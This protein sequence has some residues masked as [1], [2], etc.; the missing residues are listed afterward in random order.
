[1]LN[2]PT[3]TPDPTP[4]PNPTPD[5]NPNPAP[6]PNPDPTPVDW[7]KENWKDFLDEDLKTDPSL[8][9][10]KD[11]KTLAKSYVHAQR[12]VGADKIVVPNKYATD[13]E[14]EGIFNKLGRPESPDKYELKLPE[15]HA[16]SDEFLTGIKTTAHKAG[17]NSKQVNEFVNFYQSQLETSQK[18]I[19]ELTKA[20]TE[21]EIKALKQ[22]WGAAYDSKIKA[23]QVALK[24]FGG[25]EIFKYLEEVGLH[26]DTKLA[27][28][29]A[30]IGESLGEDKGLK[31]E[32]NGSGMLTPEEANKELANLWSN[33]AYL[34]KNHPDH[35]RL[36]EYA[37][38]LR[39]MT[40]K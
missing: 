34:D 3:P 19:E 12:L 27:K 15:K 5:P 2:D 36:V 35:E 21:K 33:P 7:N 23:A 8:K 39:S 30:K 14:W 18:K 26:T 17:L 16:I 20:E 4:N 1:M 28:L 32:K 9:S 40:K 24:Q 10:V 6:T 11:I 31:G 37:L 29:F 38:Q 25:P 22:E 13:T